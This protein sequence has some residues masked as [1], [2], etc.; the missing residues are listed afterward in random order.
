MPVI[1]VVDDS[2]AMRD[3]LS[4]LISSLGFQPDLYASGE[5]LL[6]KLAEFK[7]DAIVVDYNMEGMT[8][9]DLQLRLN[10]EG[11]C[12]PLIMVTSYFNDR[13]RA[14]ALANGAVAFLRKPFDANELIALFHN[15]LSLG[16]F[17]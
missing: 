9:L 12:P 16:K 11:K 3:A 8:G 6:C 7:A 2:F 5:E 4:D 1:A 15:D 17:C 13:L 10:A 14:T